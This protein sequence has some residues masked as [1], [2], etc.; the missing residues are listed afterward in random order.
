MKA[1]DKLPE[2]EEV[3]QESE[4]VLRFPQPEQ[5]SPPILM[6]DEVT[7]GYTKE[8]TILSSVNLNA[9]LQSRICIVGDNGA[10]KTTLLKLLIGDL[11]PVSGVRHVHRNLAIGYFT[12]H[13]V[14]QLV[15]NQ[16][17][18]QF[19]ASKQPG[20]PDEH[21]RQYLGRFG[22]TGDLAL[23]S[24]QTLS[25]GQKSRVAFAAMTLTK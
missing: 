17:P 3:Q 12:Q 25:G 7:F 21:Y 13:H 5:L 20:K 1:L 4:V 11:D 15:M 6:L 18:V 22:V 24:L 9:N 2:V 14:D 8:R 16:T 19:M 10:G 23:Q